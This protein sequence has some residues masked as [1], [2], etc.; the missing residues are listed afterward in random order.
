MKVDNL[1]LYV[2]IADPSCTIIKWMW[3]VHY[4]KNKPDSVNAA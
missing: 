4:S 3:A 1:D 2:L